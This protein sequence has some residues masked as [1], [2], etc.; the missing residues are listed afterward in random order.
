MNHYQTMSDEELIHFIQENMDTCN[1]AFQ[2]L[3]RRYHRLAYAVAKRTLSNDSDAEDVL[4]ETFIEIK[5]SIDQ[6]KNPQYFRLW[7]YRIVSNKCKN[8]YRKRKFSLV[9]SENEYVH[10]LIRDE[11]QDVNPDREMKFSSDRDM[12]LQFMHELPSGQSLVLKLFYLEQ[13]S[14]KEIS[15]YLKLPEGTVKS[16]MSSGKTSLKQKIIRYERMENTKLSFHSLDEAIMAAL[17]YETVKPMGILP[18]W[19]SK[20]LSHKAVVG[21]MVG[22]VAICC[23]VLLLSGFHEKDVEAAASSFQEMQVDGIVLDSYSDAYFY[24]LRRA[25][26][27]QDIAQM[28]LEDLT[29]LKDVYELLK[30][31]DGYH[32]HLLKEKGWTKAFEERVQM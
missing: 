12:L 26:C 3:Y 16:R 2:E 27:A 23:S 21:A 18:F 15:E 29:K 28:K 7:M 4:Q 22:G 9:D 1:D 25:C 10:N 19:K 31:S 20:L 17:L 8:L 6:L 32:Y 24:L 11:R 13:R 5:R 30:I 14:I